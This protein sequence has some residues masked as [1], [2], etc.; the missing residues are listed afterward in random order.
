MQSAGRSASSLLLCS[1]HLCTTGDLAT[2]LTFNACRSNDTLSTKNLS[3]A[4]NVIKQV[5]GDLETHSQEERLSYERAGI[6][7]SAQRSNVWETY[8]NKD[9][10]RDFMSQSLDFV[11]QHP[12]CRM[13]Q[14]TGKQIRFLVLLQH[15]FAE[16]ANDFH[17]PEA[18][19]KHQDSFEGF[20]TDGVNSQL[21]K[22]AHRSEWSVEGS[23]F[24]LQAQFAEENKRANES[25]HGRLAPAE[26]EERKQRIL[27]FQRDFVMALEEHLLA[28]CRRRQLSTLGTRR[29]IQ[30]VTTQMSQ[31]GLANLDRSSQAARYF[32]S[33]Q[34]LEQ[35]TAYNISTMDAGDGLGEAL[36]LSM[37]CMKT[38]FSSY[39]TEETLGLQNSP[40]CDPSPKTCKPASYLYQYATVRFMCHP[41]LGGDRVERTDCTVIDA[42]D[43]VHIEPND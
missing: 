4:R 38:G 29:L 6:A 11:R 12:D 41:Q 37:L 43:E 22:D 8:T 28:F 27:T 26:L 5:F 36:K 30:V 24:S 14:L 15:L 20:L 40:E 17:R 31:C 34:G 16:D 2:E 33:G 10:I 23:T 35:R 7:P 9:R 21:M 1:G 32:V 42:L 13:R 25:D 3:V 39:H 18:E 19:R